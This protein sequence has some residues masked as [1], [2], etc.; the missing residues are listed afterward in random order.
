[1]A[2]WDIARELTLEEHSDIAAAAEDNVVVAEDTVVEEEGDIAA[3]RFYSNP[4]VE[5]EDKEK[6]SART[7]FYS[8]P[9]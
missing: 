4:I 7:R 3:I 1:L 9:K 5:E 6:D 8:N 2:K